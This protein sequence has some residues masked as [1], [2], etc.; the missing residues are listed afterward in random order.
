MSNFFLGS[1]DLSKIDKSLIKM[2]QFKDG[3]TRPI[4][5]ITISK[6]K[7]PSQF[8]DTHFI[9]TAPKDTPVG[10]RNKFIIGDLRE[11]QEP[12]IDKPSAQQIE[13]SPAPSA[14]QMADLPF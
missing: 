12:T 8:G 6:R 4:L 3:T 14:E 11:W 7:Q 9:S 1:I 13:A 2:V 5:P 10:E